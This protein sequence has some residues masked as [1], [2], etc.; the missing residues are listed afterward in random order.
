MSMS[1]S[2]DIAII[3]CGPAG[4]A[5][6]LAMSSSTF[7]VLVVDAGKDLCDRVIEGSVLGFGGASLC[8]DGKFS[9][10]GA[11]SALE[12]LPA[13]EKRSATQELL[14]FFGKD[15]DI[16][17]G[18]EHQKTPEGETASF[19]LKEYPCIKTSSQER[20]DAMKAILATLEERMV[21][22]R[23]ETLV[24]GVKVVDRGGYELSLLNSES[25]VKCQAVVFAGGRLG[26]LTGAGKSIPF[27]FKRYECGVRLYL[28]KSLHSRTLNPTFVWNTTIDGLSIQFR[29]F[30]WCQGMESRC[31][32]P[33]LSPLELGNLDLLSGTTD[34]KAFGEDEGSSKLDGI[35]VGFM[36]R[37]LNDDVDL[38]ES[39]MSFVK[40]GFFD[41]S[42][43]DFVAQPHDSRW[44][45][46]LAKG[47]EEFKV[48]LDIKVD[49]VKGPCLE[50]VGVYP[51]CRPD[52]QR[53]EEAGDCLYAAGDA[54]GHV[55]GLVPSFLSGWV[56][57]AVVSIVLFN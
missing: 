13:K 45:A 20:L 10:G 18:R 2:Y 35:N 14:R 8:N 4:L 24:K 32:C 23:F 55:R 31:I 37:I 51:H 40:E 11:G 30:C 9:F 39:A 38:L 54:A 29:S 7:S 57:S 34:S 1:R 12:Y 44:M 16:E 56:I 19:R 52:T 48:A 46:I 17:S 15:W 27:C 47:L 50:G 26:P 25:V 43:E 21:S 28:K 3:G 41:L 5:A 53:C 22:F 6:A 36:A 49:R 42:E 33:D